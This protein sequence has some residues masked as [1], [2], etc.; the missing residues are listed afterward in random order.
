MSTIDIIIIIACVLASIFF[1][2]LLN[3]Y[4]FNCCIKKEIIYTPV[5][6]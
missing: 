6:L 3:K 1:I 2:I 4:H 5:D